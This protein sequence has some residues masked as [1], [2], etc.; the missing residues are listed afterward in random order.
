[1]IPLQT[2]GLFLYVKQM[3]TRERQSSSPGISGDLKMFHALPLVLSVNS[4][5][6]AP[7]SVVH[8]LAERQE[9]TIQAKKNCSAAH[10]RTLCS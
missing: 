9:M 3:E 7:L 2:A 1:M 10:A 5:I 6:L 4:R 8:L